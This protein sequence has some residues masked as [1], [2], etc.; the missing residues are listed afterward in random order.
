MEKTASTAPGA[1]S[2][3]II[4]DF[5]AQNLVVALVRACRP[6]EIR[7]TL[8][9]F[10]QTIRSLHRLEV[11]EW[12]SRPHALVVWTL[13]ELTIPGF[14]QALQWKPFSLDQILA[15]VDEFAELIERTTNSVPAVI[16]PT[17]TLSAIRSGL[18]VLET[19]PGFGVGHALMAMNLR[20]IER[21]SS[22]PRVTVID[23][24]SWL[25]AAG[26]EAF[27]PRLWYR[28]KTPYS[29]TVF[30]SAAGDIAAMLAANRGL[31]KKIV[32][33]DL[34]NT[35]WGGV[36]GDV[37]WEGL[38]L[39]GHDATGEAFVDVQR[40][41]KRLTQRG[42]LLAIASKNEESTALQAIENHPEM[43][44]RLDDFV[45]W[46]INWKDKAENVADLMTSL[47][48][49]LDAAVFLDDS[50][51]ERARVQE[52][53]PMVL[54]PEMP[55]EPMEV[56]QFVASLRCFDNPV[57]SNED[58]TRTAMYVADRKRTVSKEQ[59]HSL[60]D[61]L[62]NLGLEIDIRDV[63]KV[64]MD[65]TLQLFQRTNQ[66]NL[67]T[68]RLTR[69]ELVDWLAQGE[70]RLWT[71][72]VAD[73]FG[74][75]GL[76][77]IVSV[78]SSDAGTTIRDFVVSCRVLGRGVEDTMLAVAAQYAGAR[79]DAKLMAGFV[80]SPKNK[81]IQRWLSEQPS[82]TS[83]GN[84]FLFQSSAVA[85]VPRHVGLRTHVETTDLAVR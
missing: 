70:R 73:R 19:K 35:L 48:L 51:F 5:N 80:P 28:A 43:V 55:S 68:R 79:G 24:Q 81:P 18:G 57:I 50:P 27:N 83:D 58:R 67:S 15:E 8:G 76:C 63:N 69:G 64:T 54:V 40:M 12:A 53:L 23:A 16:V 26:S 82:A 61:W 38:R 32:I 65:R 17:W 11:G 37:G 30:A 22:S 78:E 3:G 47:N 59:A 34:D 20:L 84:L 46:R 14:G 44:L 42:V 39:G 29:N 36:V 31:S 60:G 62:A 2:V 66:M 41:L 49:G 7:C 45:G 77:G 25:T 75:Y 10:G 72:S 52:A 6:F 33:V 4:A 71:F 1:F 74:D 85:T 13:P 21:L 9:E 56:P